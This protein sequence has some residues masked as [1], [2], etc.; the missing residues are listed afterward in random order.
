LQNRVDEGRQR[1]EE[2]V[3]GALDRVGNLFGGGDDD[4]N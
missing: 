3:G 4:E 1:L 2:E